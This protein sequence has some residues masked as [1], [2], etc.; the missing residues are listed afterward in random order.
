MIFKITLNKKSERI[1]QTKQL[2]YIFFFKNYN[3]T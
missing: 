2:I 1:S 3:Q